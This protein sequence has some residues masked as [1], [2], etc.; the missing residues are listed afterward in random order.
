MTFT[1]TYSTSQTIMKLSQSVR[2]HFVTL[3]ETDTHLI[4]CN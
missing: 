3:I 4:A 2:G 1:C